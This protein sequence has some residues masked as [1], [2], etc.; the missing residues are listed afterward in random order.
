MRRSSIRSG[1]SPGAIANSP[2]FQ[3]HNRVCTNVSRH[4]CRQRL[5][6]RTGIPHLRLIDSNR[7]PS[8]TTSA[9][10]IANSGATRKRR[11]KKRAEGGV[12]RRRQRQQ[13]RLHRRA[14][15]L[16]SAARPWDLRGYVALCSAA[17]QCGHPPERHRAASASSTCSRKVQTRALQHMECRKI[18]CDTG[19]RLQGSGHAS[20]DTLPGALLAS[21]PGGT[22]LRTSPS[23]SRIPSNP[24]RESAPAHRA[25]ARRCPNAAL[26]AP[27]PPARRDPA[28]DRHHHP[29]KTH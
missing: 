22:H 18:L 5:S 13:H 26:P 2:R 4:H 12:T 11:P 10:T 7:A 24:S 1:A 25:G 16:S 27:N 8:A 6:V 14:S 21:S 19:D 28:H 3:R 9:L 15:A 20:R 17:P 23:A 29:R